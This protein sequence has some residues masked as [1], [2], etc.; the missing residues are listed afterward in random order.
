MDNVFYSTYRPDDLMKLFEEACKDKD[1]KYERDNKKSKLTFECLK[2]QTEEEKAIE[3]PQEGFRAKVK[4][5]E[6]EKNKVA[7]EFQKMAGSSDYYRDQ[8]SWMKAII[9]DYVN[10]AVEE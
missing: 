6:V 8:M 2:E 4:F 5:S 3:L 9:S 7:I 10:C 1:I